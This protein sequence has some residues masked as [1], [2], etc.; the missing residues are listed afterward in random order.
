MSAPAGWTLQGIEDGVPV[1]RHHESPV[2]VTTRDFDL[3]RFLTVALSHFDDMT[4][5]E[6]VAFLTS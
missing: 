4:P 1:W 3:L 6:F 2:T 5:P